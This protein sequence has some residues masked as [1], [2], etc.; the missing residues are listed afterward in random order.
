VISIA[1]GGESRTLENATEQWIAQRVNQQF[2]DGGGVCV[3]VTVRTENIWVTL[4]TPDCPAFSGSRDAS[5]QESRI[6]ALWDK[7]GLR[8]PQYTAGHVIAF[9]KQIESYV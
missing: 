7:H 8:K 4:T 9:L 5:P 3:K 2:K 1:I 6:L